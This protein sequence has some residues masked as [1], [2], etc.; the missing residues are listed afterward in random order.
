MF[1]SFYNIRSEAQPVFQTSAILICAVVVDGDGKL[2]QQISFMH[3]MN[4]HAVKSC[5]FGYHSAF[6]KIAGVLGNLFLRH[7]AVLYRWVK[8]VSLGRRGNIVLCHTRH[9][10]ASCVC[11]HLKKNLRAVGV[12]ALI[13]LIPIVDKSFRVLGHTRD[14]RGADSFYVHVDGSHTC[15]NQSDA[16]F[17]P[18]HIIVL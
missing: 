7:F 5:P 4:L 6:Y 13:H 11:R 15:N 18:L 17:R 14:S 16:A 2:V 1:D 3:R 12:D 8:T 10:A 9:C